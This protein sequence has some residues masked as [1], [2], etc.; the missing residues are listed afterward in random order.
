MDM[1]FC[2]LLSIFVLTA[3]CK[4]TNDSSASSDANESVCIPLDE[5]IVFPSQMSLD[6]TFG[7]TS[8]NATWN[9]WAVRPDGS[10]LRPLTSYTKGQTSRIARVSKLGN[11]VMFYSRANLDGK[12]D[13]PQSLSQNIWVLDRG[14][15]KARPLTKNDLLA[16]L[17]SSGSGS[18]YDESNILFES[19]MDPSGAWNGNPAAGSNVWIIDA[20]GGAPRQVTKPT[21]VGF[22]NSMGALSRLSNLVVVTSFLDLAGLWNGVPSQA[23]NV[24]LASLDGKVITPI[25]RNFTKTAHTM[26]AT[27]F[28]NDDKLVMISWTALDG[29][30]DGPLGP[31][32]NMWTIKSDGTQLT[33]LTNY[34][35][36]GFSSAW[37]SSDG[38]KI[39]THAKL[40]LDASDN[41]ISSFNI[42]VL[43]PD[44]TNFF[45]LTKNTA[46]GLDS[47]GP[48]FSPDGK[49]I[50]FFSKM[51]VTGKWN[52]TSS[53]SYNLWVVN[54]DGTGLKPLTLNQNA[55][56]DT[57]SSPGYAW[58]AEVKCSKR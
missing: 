13:S 26:N 33:R 32:L 23:L 58:A 5:E 9:I 19:S 51:D 6:A 49:K 7:Q 11:Y 36:T 43:N 37:V 56:L 38:E 48:Q 44:G 12:D 2:L 30:W 39:L 14:Q 28:P 25:T 8:P 15:K 54:R 24:Y 46:A 31:Q 18:T 22:N 50:A 40:A 16:G 47:I 41:A 3:A 17:D 52:G 1:K 35:K 55:S 34:T 45:P 29:T 10:Q 53:K 27:F 20:K 4:E 21:A 57:N 42:W